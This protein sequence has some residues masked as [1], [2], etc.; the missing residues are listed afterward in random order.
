MMF[1]PVTPTDQIPSSL[2]TFALP[3]LHLLLGDFYD[4]QSCRILKVQ[5]DYVRVS[6]ATAS[7]EYQYHLLEKTSL[8][9]D[10]DQ[11][12]TPLLFPWQRI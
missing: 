4:S 5:M 3:T 9:H 2:W 1:A 6:V 12:P 11:A 10:Q 8:L 7:H